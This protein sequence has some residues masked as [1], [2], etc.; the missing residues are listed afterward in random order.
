MHQ[1]RTLEV[2][3]PRAA[4]LAWEEIDR[5]VADRALWVPIVNVRMIDFVSS[6][7][8]NYQFH[9]YWGFLASQAWLR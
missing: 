4:A 2:T 5:E 1:A 7:V 8:H 3:D 6:R 9:P